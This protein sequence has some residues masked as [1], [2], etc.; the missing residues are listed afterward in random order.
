MRQQFC[1]VN[2]MMVADP[3]KYRNSRQRT[4]I[5]EIL[6]STDSHP[7]ASW[8]YEQLKPD[9]P[10]LSLG[11][12]Y[13]NLN[14]LVEQGVVQEL[15][16]GSTFDRYD[17]IT[18]PHYHFICE[19]CGGISDVDLD[20]ESDLNTKVQETLAHKVNYHRLEFYGLCREC[21]P[22]KVTKP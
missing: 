4:R 22:E 21:L 13:R 14:I 16:F 7:T 8:V 12:V 20:H 6:R 1:R 11:T 19:A 17:G 18:R 15:K 10:S 9:F 3:K 5:L 2:V